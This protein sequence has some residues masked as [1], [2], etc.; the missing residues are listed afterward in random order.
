[1]LCGIFLGQVAQ[2]VEQWTENPCVGGSI[3]SLS[4][5][6]VM[7]ESV[8]FCQHFFY[9]LEGSMTSLINIPMAFLPLHLKREIFELNSLLRIFEK[10]GA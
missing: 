1:M 7:N 8:G 3:P 5:K 10:H 2:L 9:V 6:K 4:T